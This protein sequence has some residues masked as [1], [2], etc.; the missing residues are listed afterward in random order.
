MGGKKINGRGLRDAESHQESVVLPI[1]S[2]KSEMSSITIQGRVFAKCQGAMLATKTRAILP[3]PSI[4]T[5]LDCI[6]AY[7]W[8]PV[9]DALFPQ[10]DSV[11]IG[12]RPHTQTLD[13]MHGLQ[14][15]IEKGLDAH[16][17]SAIAQMDIRRYY[18]SIP[19]VRVY[20]YFVA[21]KCRHTGP[22]WTHERGGH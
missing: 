2:S 20:R 13:I 19:I 15:V 1:A 3:L 16:G 6:F 10:L 9:I 17:C 14:S 12:A 8:Q 4:L 22:R 11:F 7:W 5:I 18:D 21:K